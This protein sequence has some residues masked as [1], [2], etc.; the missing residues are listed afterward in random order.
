MACAILP[1]L[2]LSLAVREIT[3]SSSAF[4]A[5]DIS[6]NI[7]WLIQLRDTI[8]T[9]SNNT[10]INYNHDNVAIRSHIVIYNFVWNF[11]FGT[12]FRIIIWQKEKNVW[13]FDCHLLTCS[14][15][16]MVLICLMQNID[17]FCCVDL[18]KLHAWYHTLFITFPN[19]CLP[20]NKKMLLNLVAKM[21]FYT[22]FY[23][24][25]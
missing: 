1:S 13:F 23:I 9:K 6:S 21:R 4:S 2:E 8:Q 5:T 20:C 14:V 22:S 18:I 24:I 17:M 7:L 11:I 15:R 10:W 12:K 16:K 25:T 19:E 3:K